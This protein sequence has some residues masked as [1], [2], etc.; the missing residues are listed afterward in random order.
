MGTVAKVVVAFALVA[1]SA[2]GAAE[3]PESL[4]TYA[5]RH[6]EIVFQHGL[7]PAW[8]DARLGRVTPVLRPDIRGAAY[9]EVQVKTGAGRP[10]GFI[11]MSSK[12]HDFPIVEWSTHGQ[13]PTDKLLRQVPRGKKVAVDSTDH[14][15]TAWSLSAGARNPKV[16]RG[17]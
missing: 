8:E 10:M 17:R 11:L 4:R 15:N 3:L 14:C 13:T 12:N 5:K 16:L 7:A 6:L 2:C 9:Y 1:A